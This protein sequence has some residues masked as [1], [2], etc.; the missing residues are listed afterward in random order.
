MFCLL[1]EV[2]QRASVTSTDQMFHGV[3]QGDPNMGRKQMLQLLAL[4]QMAVGGTTGRSVW[5]S[6]E[7]TS[8]GMSLTC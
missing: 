6:P 5:C 7:P 1:A 3:G 2:G 4:G 8:S